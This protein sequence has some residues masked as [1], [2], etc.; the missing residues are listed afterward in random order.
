MTDTLKRSLGPL[1]VWGMGVGY[2]ISG[3]YFGWNL[4][5]PQSGPFGLL[6]ATLII[7]LMY[8]AFT[9]SYAELAAAIPRAGGVFVY[10]DRA[11]GH[12]SGF[13]AGLAQNIEF[14]FAPPA[15][16]AAIG[17]YLTLFFPT[18]PPIAFAILAYIL[19][20]ALNI[21]GV[22]ESAIFGVFITVLAV[23]ELLLFAGLTLPH[24]SWAK[25]S[26]DALPSGWW[27]ILPAIPFAIWFFLAIEG[28]ANMAEEVKNPRRDLSLGF[29][30]AMAT[31][32]LLA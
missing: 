21:W 6:G 24:F 14:V 22:K 4:G 12:Y 18:V 32:F 28:V 3:M 5:L 27:G 15:I 19:F 20:T 25:F 13:L 31:L 11:L 26:T 10:T 17:A 29:K 7:A 1:A 9:L 8:I 23:V 16:A 30:L 2:V